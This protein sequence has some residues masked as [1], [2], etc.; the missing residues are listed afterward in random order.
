MPKAS[1]YRNFHKRVHAHVRDHVHKKMWKHVLKHAHKIS[2]H[3]NKT[4]H[5][6]LHVW[7]LILVGSIWFMS[8]MFAWSSN[9]PNN[10]SF[11][12]PLQKVS[13]LECRTLYRNDMPDSCK[14]NLPIINWANYDAYKDNDLYRSI[15]TVLRAAPYSDSWNQKLWAHAGIDVATARGT[16]LYSIWDGEVYSAW[17]NSAY[18]NVVKIKYVYQWEIVYAVYAHMDSIDIEKWDKVTKWQRIWDTWNSG[19]TFG[20]LWWYH[21][22]FEID[23]DNYGRP[24]YSYT[25]CPD[26]SKWHYKIIQNWLCRTELFSYQYDPIR[27]FESNSTYVHPWADDPVDNNNWWDDD[28]NNNDWDNSADDNDVDDSSNNDTI[29]S[30][31]DDTTNDDNTDG[32]DNSSWGDGWDDTVDKWKDVIDDSETDD[33]IWDNTDDTTNDDTIDNNLDDIED[34]WK[35]IIDDGEI[36][37]NNDWVETDKTDDATDDDATDSDSDNTDQTENPI[38]DSSDNT[39][40]NQDD[41]SWDT[42]TTDNSDT[43][44]DTDNQTPETIDDK[45]LLELDFDWV[46]TL[47]EHLTNLWDVEMRSELKERNLLLGETVTLD[48][49]VFKKWDKLDNEQKWDTRLNPITRFNWVLQLPFVLITTNDN[50]DINVNYLKLITKGEAQV[51]ITGKKSWV[52]HLIIEFWGKKIWILDITV[53]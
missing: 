18:G 12:Y 8:L 5:W 45:Y 37:D 14:I 50:I 17:R 51:E 38:D 20:A 49:E 53:N 23:K 16:P 29:D 27:L 46:S 43:T 39:D 13:T 36:D 28:Q 34:K 25:N 6:L 41:Q 22:H 9:L 1:S 48:I 21:V 26:L 33:N 19:N 4:H 7:E 35:D 52:S 40:I 42:D 15:Y 2:H 32:I 10:T 44:Q 11:N 3:V 31:G 30:N 24:A 47:A